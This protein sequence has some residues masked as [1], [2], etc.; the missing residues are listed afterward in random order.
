MK[1]RYGH[2][3]DG[4]SCAP[5]SGS[6]LPSTEPGTDTV[7]ARIADGT[8]AEVDGAVP[9]GM[10]ATTVSVPGSVDVS[11]LPLAGAQLSPSIQCP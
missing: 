4:E 6:W 9:S 5:A 8:A 1:N 2:W 11:Q 7:V 10:C 3:I